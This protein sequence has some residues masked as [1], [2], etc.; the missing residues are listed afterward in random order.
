M[1]LLLLCLLRWVDVSLALGLQANL[2]SYNLQLAACCQS[3]YAWLTAWLECLSVCLALDRSLSPS[4]SVRPSCR[5]CYSASKLVTWRPVCVYCGSSHCCCGLFGFIVFIFGLRHQFAFTYIEHAALSAELNANVEATTTTITAYRYQQAM[6][7]SNNT[8]MHLV[9]NHTHKHR[10]REQRERKRGN[11]T[12]HIHKRE[13][14]PM[15]N[16]SIT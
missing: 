12:W 10:V 16:A 15:A 1:L 8:N 14:N 13:S 2:S 7:G 3:P 6:L 9:Y 11:H 5:V 4:L